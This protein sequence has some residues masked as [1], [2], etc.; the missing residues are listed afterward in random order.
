LCLREQ[1]K[2]IQTSS[3][4]LKGTLKGLKARD[5]KGD[6]LPSMKKMLYRVVV[7]FAPQ[8]DILCAACTCLAGL[9]LKV[10]GK[11]NYVGGVLFTGEDFKRRGL[12]NHPKPLTCTS[13][14]SVWVV[15]HNQS[16]AAKP[17]DQILIRKIRFGKSIKFDPRPPHQHA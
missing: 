17:L 4:S 3:I 2:E 7:E 5:V 9:G 14:L 10:K 11:C 6:V 15:Q 13:H 8:C 16:I 12:Q 1:I